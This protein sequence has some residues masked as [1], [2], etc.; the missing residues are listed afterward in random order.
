[1]SE[2]NEALGVTDGV[3]ESVGAGK[4]APDPVQQVA[5]VKAEK[6]GRSSAGPPA[7]SSPGESPHFTVLDGKVSFPTSGDQSKHP[8]TNL[9]RK[10]AQTVQKTSRFH[11]GSSG[12]EMIVDGPTLFHA[13]GA[14]EG[15]RF[16]RDEYNSTVGASRGMS[17]ELLRSKRHGYAEIAASIGVALSSDNDVEVDIEGLDD[18]VEHIKAANRASLQSSESLLADGYYEFDSLSALYPPGSYVVA[19]HAGGGGIDC[20]CQVVWHRYVSCLAGDS[21]CISYHQLTLLQY[22]T[23]TQGKTI[24]GKP[25][26]YFQ[27]CCRF[28]APVGSGKSTFAEVVEGIEMFEGRRSLSASASG[29]G[30]AFVPVGGEEREGLFRRYE[31]RGELYNRITPARGEVNGGKTSHCYMEYEKG[32][33]FQKRGGGS[34]NSG[35][36]SLVLAAPGRI[37]VDLD[38]ALEN[39][40]SISVG[41]DDLIDGIRMKVKEYNLHL[42]SIDNTHRGAPSTNKP[43][44]DEGS[45]GMILFHQLPQEYLALIWP[46][47]IGFSLTSK[48][49]GDVA[50]D[51][52]SDIVFDPT[53]F[54]RLV[55]PSSRKRMIK[56]LVKHSSIGFHD[57]VQGK[58]EGTCFLLHGQVRMDSLLCSMELLFPTHSAHITIQPGTGKTLTAEAIAESL[59]CPLYSI[60]MGTLGTTADELERRLS[61]ILELSARWNALVLLDEADSF[62]EARS[63]NSPLERNAMV[64]V[65]LR[66]VEYHR[67]ILFLTSNRIESLDPAFQTRITLS[68]KYEPL[69][70]EGRAKV[71]ENLLLKSGQTL[72]SLDLVMLAK[73]VLNGREIKNALRLA[74][75]L[76]VDEGCEL[77]QDLLLETVEV[78]NSQTKGEGGKVDKRSGWLSFLWA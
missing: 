44:D 13:L 41:R 11:V 18:L 60:S 42:R 56:A 26:K 75:A 30:L 38:A 70:L 73:P 72:D 15:V 69:D 46:T 77:S 34:F 9:V 14:F 43:S 31:L 49:W 48:S 53:V 27:L 52:L 67:G 17:D 37:V 29:A 71:W 54:D 21:H 32:S 19:K 35:K 6:V 51:G 58:G 16:A 25:M 59:H 28:I 22:L 12:G 8:L 45:R 36:S 7:S 50:I 40:H 57:L 20:L 63:T 55:L 64:S 4:K 61:E 10:M 39:G 78:V 66:L 23:Q 76:A 33:F 1:M 5:S 62:L 68:L 3:S 74:M 47:T 2:L 24:S 65:M